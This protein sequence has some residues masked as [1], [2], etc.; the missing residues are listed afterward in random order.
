MVQTFSLILSN[1]LQEYAES[2][3]EPNELSPKDIICKYFCY[4]CLSFHC[5]EAQHRLNFACILNAHVCWLHGFK[6]AVNIKLQECS[7]SLVDT[8]LTKHSCSCCRKHY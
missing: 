5:L 7:P 3:R 4:W 6:E 2:Y 1:T 8:T